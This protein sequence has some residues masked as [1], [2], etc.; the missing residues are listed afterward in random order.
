MLATG[1][2]VE[3][4]FTGTSNYLRRRRL[5]YCAGQEVSVSGVSENSRVAESFHVAVG[6]DA[7]TATSSI[8]VVDES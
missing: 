5:A 1:S 2:V 8:L 6:E 4:S 3:L 7:D